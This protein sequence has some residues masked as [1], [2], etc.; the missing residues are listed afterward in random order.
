VLTTLATY[1][2]LDAN[3]GYAQHSFDVSAY[4]GQTVTV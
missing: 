3:T 1:S 4:A 2:N